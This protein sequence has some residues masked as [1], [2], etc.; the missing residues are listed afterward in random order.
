MEDVL[1]VYHRPYN[2]RFPVIGRSGFAAG[3]GSG[4]DGLAGLEG[5]RR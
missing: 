2:P 4:L 3:G 5:T 1:E